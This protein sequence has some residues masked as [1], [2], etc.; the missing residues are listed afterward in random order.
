MQAGWQAAGPLQAAGIRRPQ[1]HTGCKSQASCSSM[2]GTQA[3]C[4]VHCRLPLGLI[5][6]L[7]VHLRLFWAFLVAERGEGGCS[8]QVHRIT[9]IGVGIEIF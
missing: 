7:Q 4:W 8:S 1:A 9:G 2:A 3:A 5:R 6:R